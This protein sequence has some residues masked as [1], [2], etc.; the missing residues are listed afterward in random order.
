M[1]TLKAVRNGQKRKRLSDTKMDSVA[2]ITFQR[3]MVESIHTFNKDLLKVCRLSGTVLA[4]EYRDEH[5]K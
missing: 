2:R 5:N 3:R 1:G 4:S